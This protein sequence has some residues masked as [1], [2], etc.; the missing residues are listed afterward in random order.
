[1]EAGNIAAKASPGFSTAG[2][3]GQTAAQQ[4]MASLAT[5]SA[6][7]SLE[8]LTLMAGLRRLVIIDS[9]AHLKGKFICWRG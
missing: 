9:S 3:G 5:A 7:Q 6:A 8:C 2:A 1:M 4:Q